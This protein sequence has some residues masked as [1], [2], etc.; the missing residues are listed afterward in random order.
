VSV[1]NRYGGLVFH[2]KNVAIPW[3]GKY[4][5]IPQPI[6]VYVFVIALKD[7]N[8]LIKGTVMLIR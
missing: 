2:T 4:K 3:D 6:G 8:R 5:G 1:Y 7:Q